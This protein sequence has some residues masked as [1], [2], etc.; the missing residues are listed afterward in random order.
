MTLCGVCDPHAQFEE[1][2]KSWLPLV[3]RSTLEDL[4]GVFE[5]EVTL[6]CKEQNSSYCYF[7]IITEMPTSGNLKS[8]DSFF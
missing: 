7:L 5:G 3:V 4:A 6:A 2:H 8:G 1:E